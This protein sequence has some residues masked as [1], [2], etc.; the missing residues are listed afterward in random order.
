EIMFRAGIFV[1]LKDFSKIDID[2]RER[3]DDVEV[4]WRK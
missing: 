1:M 4:K 2:P 3:T